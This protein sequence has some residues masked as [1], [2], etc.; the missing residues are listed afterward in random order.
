M[1]SISDS[2]YYIDLKT[3]EYRKINVELGKSD[4][5]L[6]G[7]TDSAGA[8]NGKTQ[9]AITRWLWLRDSTVYV[10]VITRKA[11]AANR[12]YMVYAVNKAQ[13]VSGAF[14]LGEPLYPAP[15]GFFPV[16]YRGFTL[17]PFRSSG[18]AATDCLLTRG[19]DV[20]DTIYHVKES[21]PTDDSHTAPE[22]YRLILDTSLLNNR[23]ER[24]RT[25]RG[26]PKPSRELNDTVVIFD[27]NVGGLVVA[28]NGIAI[29]TIPMPCEQLIVVKEHDKPWTMD[30][31]VSN[32]CN[33]RVAAS[34]LV[35]E[36]STYRHD[37][38]SQH[39][40]YQFFAIID[41]TQR[42]NQ[43]FYA[44][45]LFGHYSMILLP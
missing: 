27:R 7:S 38:R 24:Y 42:C 45:P 35:A 23:I 11:N 32:V 14:T 28:E 19:A 40:A 31:A 13:I 4:A 2:L 8:T 20:V 26:E 15:S 1:M 5:L 43:R 6:P 39:N 18:Q 29:D 10:P 44:A 22:Y 41:I 37:N 30:A 9:F 36:R 25:Q 3:A 12:E 21:K 34:V 16:Q 33:G 17:V